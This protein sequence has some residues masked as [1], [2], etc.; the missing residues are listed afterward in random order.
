MACVG[1]LRWS[2][3]GSVMGPFGRHE[4]IIHVRVSRVAFPSP[5]PLLRVRLGTPELPHPG[6]AVVV[7]AADE[8]REAPRGARPPEKLEGKREGDRLRADVAERVALIAG[9]GEILGED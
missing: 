2:F 6:A 3:V 1:L 9:G 5:G 8:D 4:D 7:L